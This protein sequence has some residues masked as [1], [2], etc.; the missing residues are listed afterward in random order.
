MKRN[1]A[2]FLSGCCLLVL[3]DGLLGEE[4]RLAAWRF[5]QIDVVVGKALSWDRNEAAEMKRWRA[6]DHYSCSTVAKA[7][8]DLPVP[9]VSPEQFPAAKRLAK[10][11]KPQRFCRKTDDFDYG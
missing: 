7:L 11:E 6:S 2:E 9:R 1:V 10:Y 4:I 3:L 5:C 8:D